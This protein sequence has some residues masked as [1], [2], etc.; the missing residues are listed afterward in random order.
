MARVPVTTE[1]AR[2][3]QALGN[4][5]LRFS[6]ARDFA[7]PAVQQFGQALGQAGEAF[8][9]IEATYD[10]ADALRLDNQLRETVRERTLTG[11]DAF[12]KRRG[13]NAGEGAEPFVGE[14][15]GEAERLL[16]GARSE[17][18]RSM[19]RRAFATRLETTQQT[20][21][22]HAVREME[23]ARL[24]QSN[25]RISGAVTDAI[26][27]RGTDQFAVNLGLAQQ[28][29][30]T[31]AARLGWS[32]EQLSEENEKLVSNTYAQTVLAFDAEDGEPTRALAFLEEN[33][34][35]IL[36]SE[37]ARLTSALA[38]RVDAA[39]ADGEV[40][41][42]A[43]DKYLV[44]PPVEASPEG[45]AA[46]P[47]RIVTSSE[48]Q[49][50]VASVLS[51][52]G[53]LPPAVVAGFLGNFEVE[54]GYGGARG[55]GGTASGIAQW[56]GDRRANFRRQF[57]K[58]PHQASAAE[59]AQFVVWELNNPQQA[60]MT[61]AQRD[62][63]LAAKTPGEA[64]ALIDQY[65]E[66]SSGQHRDRRV[67][68]A[69]R[70][71]ADGVAPGAP[72][73]AADPRLDSRQMRDAVDAYISEN[74]G[75]SERRKQAL[76][77]AA[78]QAVNVARADRAQAEQDADRRLQDWLS[79]N[80]PGPDDLTS[81]DAIPASIRSGISP[82]T[83]A[84]L[85]NRVQITQA[86]AEDRAARLEAGRAAQL[87][88]EAVFELY[89]MSD[90]E[91][92]R[93]D[94]RKYAGRIGIERLGPWFERAEVAN[95]RVSGGGGAFVKGDRIASRI[96]TLGKDF[97]AS[98][99]LDADAD[100]RKLWADVRGYVEERVAGRADKDVTDEE[101]R[102]IILGGFQE[103]QVA[104]SGWFGSNFGNSTVPRAQLPSGAEVD[105]DDIPKAAAADVRAGL[106]RSGVN[107]PTT[108]QI[109]TAYQELRAKGVYQ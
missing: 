15:Q 8:D 3:T 78:D 75:L 22:S 64:A 77:A 84:A 5:R 79:E 55:D 16:Q 54:G 65:Y 26:D 80:M 89:T 108:S 97:K 12:L 27:A 20:I 18:A 14:L 103:A 101:L 10:E 50:S 87:E 94:L 68:E 13:F 2:P 60:G 106:K 76:Y 100:E 58:D 98:R 11:E 73:V 66:R 95:R 82:S 39:W 34:D 47:G 90:A 38:P 9:R 63:I 31:T 105:L 62:R 92:A 52:Q 35:A 4:E 72:G 1:F 69:E 85:Q 37:Q 41:G 36:P 30:G 17:R 28:E 7:G 102:S 51:G 40:A 21:G 88:A 19:A 67:K 56:R 59:Q 109:W 91:L 29:L 53:N 46:A 45:A 43:L 33:K 44:A 86:R 104:G 71:A 70:F 107:N 6:Q 48:Q 81:V 24:E 96:D 23:S 42:G 32:P 61:V 99:S 25:A 49:G 57:G 83:I 93:T 74:P